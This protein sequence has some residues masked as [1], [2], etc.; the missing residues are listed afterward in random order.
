MA[1][2][3]DDDALQPSFTF[4]DLPRVRLRFYEAKEG[5][6]N[7]PACIV[8]Y[9]MYCTHPNGMARCVLKRK[10]KKSCTYILLPTKK[11]PK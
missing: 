2:D 4:L 5:K 1:L 8:L 11:N 10:K 9:V 3:D 7:I 6:R